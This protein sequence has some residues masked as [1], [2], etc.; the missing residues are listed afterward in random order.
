MDDVCSFVF[1][2]AMNEFKF[3]S[4]TDIAKE[5]KMSKP[6]SRKMLNSLIDDG[7]LSIVYE[8]PQIKIYAPKELVAKIVRI[9]RKPS[10]V[11]KHSLPN[12]TDF[13]AKK[14]EVD[15]ALYEYERFEELLYQ[16]D[17]PLEDAAA[18]TFD[19]L[20]FEVRKLPKGAY[21]DFEI[22]IGDFLAAVEASGSYGS[23]TMTEVRQLIHYHLDELNKNRE[24][25]NLILLFNHYC[26]EDPDQRKEPFA[27]NI[28]TAAQDHGITL[29]T[30]IQLYRKIERVK[31][32]EL[33]EAIV[34]EII[35]GNWE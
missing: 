30:T 10:W 8:N 21:A 32:G 1:D 9:Q 22:S 20:G 11:D 35:D 12:K 27:P 4:V 34:K 6:K 16:Q 19:W 33:K 17:T 18:F 5:F 23:C 26:K 3:S 28:I 25:P 15:D 2:K 31:S 7:R 14:K 29:V 24:I 13:A